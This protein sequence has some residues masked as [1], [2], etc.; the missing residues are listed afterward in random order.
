MD[1]LTCFPWYAIWTLFVPKHNEN[2][3]QEDHI[4]N[5]H[6]YHC[7]I[8]MINV[9]QIYKLYAAFWAKSISALKRVSI[10]YT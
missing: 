10:L 7:I 4:N 2:H 3:T 9:L 1:F 6:F 5:Y 8:R